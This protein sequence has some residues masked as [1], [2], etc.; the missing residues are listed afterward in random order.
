MRPKDHQ[1][2]PHPSMTKE[3]RKEAKR[4][5]KWSTSW[6]NWFGIH[7]NVTVVPE[8]DY[9]AL[10]KKH[11][12]RIKQVAELAADC[13]NWR[14][15]AESWQQAAEVSRQ[16]REFYTDYS[17]KVM[18]AMQALKTRAEKDR[19]RLMAERAALRA[20]IEHQEKTI[21]EENQARLRLAADRAELVAAL[22]LGRSADDHLKR[23][24]LLA[25][26]G[27]E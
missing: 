11:I 27:A 9:L 12:D 1:P 3:G 17:E 14:N 18:N 20:L 25:R 7:D 26:L 13:R 5:P 22:R 8:S 23:Q 15:I 16:P 4:P 24:A 21:I 2:L 10:E 19:D 6:P